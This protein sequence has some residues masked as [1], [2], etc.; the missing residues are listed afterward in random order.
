MTCTPIAPRISISKAIQTNRQQP[1]TTGKL[2]KKASAGDLVLLSQDEAR[3]SMMPTLRTTLGVKGYRPVVGNLDCHDVLDVFGA[4]DL[5]TGRL[6]TRMGE[7]PR[8]PMRAPQRSRQEAFARHVRAIART[9]PA[10]H[11]PRVVIVIDKA[12]W[13]RGAGSTAVLAAFPH[14]E[15]YPLPSSSPK[16][17]VIERFWKVLRRRAT[18]HRLFPTMAQLK[19]ALRNSLC[20]YQTLK[21]RV[22]S[23]IQSVRKRSKSSAA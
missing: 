4:L 11:Y 9:S 21:H 19:Q 17:Q 13:H 6:T 15:L 18:H 16:L 7:R 3:F 10:A 23:V 12:S 8:P 2:S 5:V 20:Y 1:A 22:L 14:L